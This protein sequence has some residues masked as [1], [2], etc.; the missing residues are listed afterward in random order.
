MNIGQY[1]IDI[2]ETGDFALDGGAMFGVVPKPLWSKSYHEGDESNR[3]AMTARCLLIRSASRTI[4]VDTGC[5]DKMPPK[6]RSVYA[7]DNSAKSIDFSLK[8][9]GLTRADITDVILTHLH[10][11]HAGGATMA[12]N[13]EIVPTFPNAK[14][15]V[16]KKHYEWAN[17]PSEKDR[18]SFMPEN[19]MPVVHA[20]MME[21]TDGAGEILPGIGVTPFF[22]HTQAMQ[23]VTVADGATTLAFPADLLPTSAHIPLPYIMGY[24]NFPLTTLDEKK[25]A[26]PRMADEEWIVVFEHDRFTAA[27]KVARSE[28][29]FAIGER[30]AE[31]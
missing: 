7:L 13:N 9:Y 5:G 26:L 4:L 29:G 31:L 14:Y 3:I 20:G 8:H 30:I 16:Q 11:D 18:A 28:K 1:T 24:D 17:A 12:E 2:F 15:Y 22:G 23:M 25:A 6:M 10:F 19:W 27:G 21:L